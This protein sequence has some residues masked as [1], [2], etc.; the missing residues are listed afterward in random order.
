MTREEAK[1]IATAISFKIEEIHRVSL[2][3][4]NELIDQI[5]NYCEAELKKYQETIYKLEE[6]CGR[7][8]AQA[9]H[10]VEVVEELEAQIKAKEIHFKLLEQECFLMKW[11]Y[12]KANAKARSIV[13][14][15]GKNW[16][17]SRQFLGKNDEVTVSDQVAFMDAI[18]ILKHKG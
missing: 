7:L 13:A 6:E 8:T 4:V 1:N 16:K 10:G 12:S 18:T 2:T 5:Y 14:K 15:L 11:K 3:G 9:E 17:R